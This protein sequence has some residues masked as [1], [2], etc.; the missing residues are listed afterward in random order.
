[1]L[2]EC[3]MLSMASSP[4]EYYASPLY[5]YYYDLPTKWDDL[6]FIDGY[7]QTHA[8]LARKC[9]AL[10][11]VS[12]VTA[13][14]RTVTIP[15]DYLDGGTYNVAVY[16]DNADGS[17]GVASYTTITN[18]DT[19]TFDLL[20]GGAVIL[21]IAPADNAPSKITFN[22]DA[23]ILG[24]NETQKLEYSTDKTL[25]PDLVW[26]SSDES[27]VKV[28]NGRVTGVGK[29]YATATVKSAVNEAVCDTVS[30]HVF[31][32]IDLDNVWSI[33]NIATKAG[34]QSTLDF[35]N[36]YRI[37]VPTHTGELGYSDEKMPYNVWMM[38][39]PKGDFSVTVKV[40]GAM[41]HNYNSASLGIYAD[42]S[43]VIQMARRFHTG[44]AANVDAV[45]SKLGSV[46]NVISF[47]TRTTKYNEKYVAD[48]K[49][50]APLWMKIER[51][52]N[53]FHGYYS[54]DGVNFTEM[55]GTQSNVTVAAC[56]NPKIV[57]A[58]HVGGSE[59][60]VM[61]IDFEDVTVNG[62]K[63]PFTKSVEIS[64]NDLKLTDVLKVLKGVV[65]KEYIFA[66]DTDR[67]G[68]TGVI[69]ILKLMKKMVH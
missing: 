21:K 69:D 40:T 3:G 22:E 58:C 30:V 47:M 24:V 62:E 36:P 26:T 34:W 44:L 27:V 46:G 13:D 56:E 31:G 29:G 23:L 45:P 67:D 14:A 57:L 7:P 6:H 10:W 49:F 54:Y 18:K 11:Y 9:G 61:D 4:A 60:Y 1:T 55:P 28:V 2:I 5:W 39:A 53:I 17:E 52:G 25:F 16:A 32:G 43:S 68:K 37:T 42:N 64:S 20:N 63:I 12:A 51:V 35:V 38:D 8:I 48:T 41:T 66:A 15:F 50:A 19:L 33:G 65:N 59:T